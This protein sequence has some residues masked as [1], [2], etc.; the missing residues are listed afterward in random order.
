MANK[1]PKKKKP[2]F[3]T[4]PIESTGISILQIVLMMIG[5]ALIYLVI[6]WVVLSGLVMTP[7][8]ACVV[9]VFGVIFI[10]FALWIGK[11]R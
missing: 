3:N 4:Q 9:S 8:M 1:K 6:Q 7:Q 2:A 10:I 11:R 5:S